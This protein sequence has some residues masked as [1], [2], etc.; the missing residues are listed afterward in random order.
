MDS[1]KQLLSQKSQIKQ[2]KNKSLN[3][4]QSDWLYIQ[5]AIQTLGKRLVI[6]IEGFD[7]SGKGGVIRSLTEVID[8]RSYQVHPISAPTEIEKNQHYLQRFWNKLPQKGM[9]SL[10]DRSWYGRVLVE[11][12][13]KLTPLKR[14]NEAYEEINQ[15]EMMLVAD[16][17][18][19]MKFFL[20]VSKKEQL[21][22]FKDRLKDPLKNWKITNDDLKNRS[23]WNQY[24]EAVEKMLQLTSKI[25]RWHVIPSDNKEWT[26][27]QVLKIICDELKKLKPEKQKES[28]KKR[29]K[30]LISKLK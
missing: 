14:I 16:D 29:A 17:I 22:R 18:I 30:I 21:Q 8:P 25:K 4:L 7:A 1:I 27:T 24:V 15:F 13:E 2:T 19:V 3:A 20:A 12:V 5:S 6:V 10:F 9:I 26:R 28:V 23:H 11:K